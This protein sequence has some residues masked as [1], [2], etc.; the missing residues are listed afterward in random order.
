M[1]QYP[2]VHTRDAQI[3]GVSRLVRWYRPIAVSTVGKYKFLFLL[4]KLNKHDSGFRFSVKVGAYCN[5]AFGCVFV[6]ST[7][8]SPS[9]E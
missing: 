2:N 6:L 4:P 7:L 1:V 3:I 9:S 5:F 8:C